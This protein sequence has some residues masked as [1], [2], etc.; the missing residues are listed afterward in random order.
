MIESAII[1][2]SF[3]TRSIFNVCRECEIFVE[4]MCRICCPIGRTGDARSRSL[5]YDLFVIKFPMNLKS[6]VII[7][8][9]YPGLMRI[10]W[11]EYVRGS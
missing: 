7:I 4:H 10:R 11:G 2:V 3:D 8:H 6:Y 5:T 1:V 9:Q